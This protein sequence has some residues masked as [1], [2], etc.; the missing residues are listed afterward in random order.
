MCY[1]HK[2][3]IIETHK[4]EERL[5]EM[6]QTCGRFEINGGRL[7]SLSQRGVITVCQCKKCGEVKHIKTLLD[8]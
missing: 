5:T 3:E 7:Y 8:D 2:W 6:M 4:F 1:N